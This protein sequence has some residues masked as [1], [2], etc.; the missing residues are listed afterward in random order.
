V[1]PNDVG[2]TDGV[3]NFPVLSAATSRGKHRGV[4]LTGSL[5]SKPL[6]SYRVEFFANR[7]ANPSGYG[8]G[9]SH[10]GSVTVVTDASGGASFEFTASE[11]S[12]LTFTATATSAGGATS[13][14]GPALTTPK[15]R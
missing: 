11:H 6:A 5:S 4:R 15:E 7:V 14:F 8:E 10:L 9:E 2:D 12:G 1:T 3:Q 13:E